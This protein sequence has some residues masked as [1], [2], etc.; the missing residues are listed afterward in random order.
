MK[1]G[2]KMAYIGC[3][4]IKRHF[5][6]ISAFG[7]RRYAEE[8]FKRPGRLSCLQKDLRQNFSKVWNFGKVS[9]LLYKQAVFK[10][11]QFIYTGI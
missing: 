9:K 2:E 1:R 11:I 8:D 7:I 6:Q 4:K 5:V 3:P 10:L